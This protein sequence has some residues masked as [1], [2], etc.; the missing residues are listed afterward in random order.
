MAEEKL[1]RVDGYT[2]LRKDTSTGGVVNVDK[3]SYESYQLSK[4]IALKQIE[5]K[6]ITEETIENIQTELTAVKNDIGEIKGMLSLLLKM[7]P[8]N[9]KYNNWLCYT[10]YI[11]K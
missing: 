9:Y 2:N 3:N 5:E 1:V 11:T 6:K 7:Q 8:N 4:R 10:T